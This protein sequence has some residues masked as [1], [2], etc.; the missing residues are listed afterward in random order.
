MNTLPIIEIDPDDRF[1]ELRLTAFM[2]Y[3]ADTA[4]RGEWLLRNCLM[5]M[6]GLDEEAQ[7]QGEADEECRRAIGAGLGSI[8]HDYGG[9][10]SFAWVHLGKHKA[11]A[12]K[13]SDD[14]HGQGLY[15]GNLLRHALYTVGCGGVK[16]AAR[17][18]EETTGILRLAKRLTTHTWPQFRAASH[19]WAA[20]TM[21]G[22]FGANVRHGAWLKLR[23]FQPGGL[24]GFLSLAE[25]VRQKGE[26][27]MPQRGPRQP[28][29]HPGQTWAI[30]THRAPGSY[31]Q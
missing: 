7:A 11:S 28:V 20:F 4:A 18:I 23:Q 21:A 5:L 22:A 27:T 17:R 2:Y 9:W 25:E 19:L 10:G 13:E 15:A 30:S 6:K 31:S 24:L 14:R 26:I 16:D 8:V 12:Q 1:V 29:L 3:P